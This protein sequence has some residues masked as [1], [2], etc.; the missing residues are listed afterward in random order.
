MDD[1]F[2]F[3]DN[4]SAVIRLYTLMYRHMYKY[5]ECM[6]IMISKDYT[7]LEVIIFQ[8]QKGSFYDKIHIKNPAY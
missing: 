3:K 7:K 8:D 1:Y 2:E 6:I 5:N 4:L